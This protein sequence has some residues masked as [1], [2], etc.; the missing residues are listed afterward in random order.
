MAGWW[1]VSRANNVTHEEGEALNE[2]HINV[3]SY[4]PKREKARSSLL[5]EQIRGQTCRANILNK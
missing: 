4:Y 1:V 5:K 3:S 2:C